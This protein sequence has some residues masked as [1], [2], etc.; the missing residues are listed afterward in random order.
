MSPSPRT[1]HPRR[2]SRRAAAVACAALLTLASA[3]TANAAPAGRQAAAAAPGDVVSA[4]AVSLPGFFYA[5]AWQITYRSTDTHGRPNVVSGTVIVPT[6]PV[7]GKRPI[8]S[9]A[10]GTHGLGDQCAPSRRLV[11]GDD[12]EGLLIHQYASRGYAVAIT[13]YEGLGTP[14]DHTYVVGRAAGHAVL[15][16]VRAAQRLPDAGLAADAP[17]AVSGYSQGGQAAGWAAELASDYAPDLRLK[18]VAVGAPPANLTRVAE[19]NDG[20]AN[21]GLVLAAGVGLDTAY[22]ELDIESY[23]NEAGQAAYTDIRDDCTGDFS[24]YANKTL[25]DHTHTNPLDSADWQRRLREQGL[26]SGA[27]GIP[28]LLYHSLTDEIIPF[29]MSPVLRDQWR[30][31]GTTVTFWPLPTGTHVTTAALASPAVVGWVADRLAA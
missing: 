20:G 3:S 10:V 24:K 19:Y 30:A 1:P 2:L 12:Q 26:G 31:A 29:D 21:S 23:L 8:V 17:V 5:R 28:V 6:A 13:D 18:G 9:Y 7:S 27:P 15:D 14:G 22:P 11:A 4:Q 16:V 25:D